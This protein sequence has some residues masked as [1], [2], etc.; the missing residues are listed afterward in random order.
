MT[1]IDYAGTW[2]YKGTIQPSISVLPKLQ[3]WQR[4]PYATNSGSANVRLSY[5]GDFSKVLTYGYL[6]LVY[7][8]GDLVFGKWKRFYPKEEKEVFDLE[9]PEEFLINSLAIPRYF[10]VTK[11]YKR[12]YRGY[13]TY[14]DYPWG[15]SIEALEQTALPSEISDL[16]G[17][18]PNRVLNVGNSGNIV[19]VLEQNQEIV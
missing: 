11:V 9:V 14:Q 8:M 5:Y 3:N 4:F 2:G 7:D 12:R 6:R 18:A 17:S 10:E 15:V 19:I 1:A 16:L 13:G